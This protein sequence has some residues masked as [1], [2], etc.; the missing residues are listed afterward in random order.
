MNDTESGP[1]VDLKGHL[2]AISGNLTEEK[3]LKCQN[4]ESHKIIPKVLPAF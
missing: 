1:E 4:R 3:L 2:S